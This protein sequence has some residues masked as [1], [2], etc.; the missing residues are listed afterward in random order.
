MAESDADMADI[1]TTDIPSKTE[2][3][4]NIDESK[5]RRRRRRR[6]RDRH[7]LYVLDAVVRVRVRAAEEWLCVSRLPGDADEEEVEAMAAQY[8]RV[9]EVVMVHSDKTGRR[10]K[11]RFERQSSYH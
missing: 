2:V 9:E 8:G 1:T 10:E 7:N 4:N 3:N 11:L 5:P 6:K